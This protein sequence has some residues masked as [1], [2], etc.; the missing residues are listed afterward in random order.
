MIKHLAMRAYV[1]AAI[2]YVVGS[3]LT[4]SQPVVAKAMHV[5]LLGYDVIVGRGFVINR[6]E[7]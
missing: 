1:P 3:R 4:P 2:G 7:R 6:S 5:V